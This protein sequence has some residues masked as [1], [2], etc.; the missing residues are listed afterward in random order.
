MQVGL[1]RDSNNGRDCLHGRDDHGWASIS[2]TCL[3]S[4]LL[5]SS[6]LQREQGRAAFHRLSMEAFQ[7][8]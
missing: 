5:R 6:M 3:K 8:L 1:G 7:V 2:L 4:L